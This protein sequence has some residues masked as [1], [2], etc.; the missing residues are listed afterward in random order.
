LGTKNIG[1]RL[2]ILEIVYDGTTYNWGKF[3]ENGAE[4]W[5]C[6]NY[7][8]LDEIPVT[9]PEEEEPQGIPGDMDGNEVV[10]E[11][12]AIYL[13]RHVLFPDMYVIQIDADVNADGNVNEDDAIYL[14]R[15]VLFPDMYP[16]HPTGN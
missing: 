13:L 14:L 4:R 8:T 12:D 15:H 5:I 3:L 7:V 2:E 1:D 11:D 6:M 9:P 16:L 10:N